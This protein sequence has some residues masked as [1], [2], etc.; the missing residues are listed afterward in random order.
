MFAKYS[1]PFLFSTT[2]Y[3]VMGGVGTKARKYNVGIING[4]RS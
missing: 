3:L 4:I 2:M 1:F